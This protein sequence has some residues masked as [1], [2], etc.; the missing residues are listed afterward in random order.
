[1]TDGHIGWLKPERGRQPSRHGG[2]VQVTECNDT[3][4]I[5]F[6]GAE[7][8][9]V[10]HAAG[11]WMAQHSHIAL[12]AVSWGGDQIC[13]HDE[14]STAHAEYLLQLVVS[15]STSEGLAPMN[16]APHRGEWTSALAWAEAL[17]DW[18]R[19]HHPWQWP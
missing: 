6:V 2:S 5:E 15:V 17:T 18:H 14:Q 16:D 10:L 9:D 3:R 11:T 12:H 19:Q 13:E 8:S 7:E 1:M 4:L